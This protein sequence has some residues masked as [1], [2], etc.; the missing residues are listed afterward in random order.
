MDSGG[1]DGEFG[2]AGRGGVM[3]VVRDGRGVD[4]VE[5]DA[6][7]EITKNKVHFIHSFWPPETIM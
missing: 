3:E 5:G 6:K 4:E 2:G 1:G 7:N